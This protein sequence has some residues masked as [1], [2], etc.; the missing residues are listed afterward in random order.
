MP[1]RTLLF[2]DMDKLSDLVFAIQSDWSVT[3]THQW[4][5]YTLTFQESLGER[6]QLVPFTLESSRFL[7]GW[8]NS[9]RLQTEKDSKELSNISLHT[10]TKWLEK[11]F[12]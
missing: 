5:G 10:Y 8:D 11:I 7:K 1:D 12:A 3:L 6:E 4:I 2:Q 9:A